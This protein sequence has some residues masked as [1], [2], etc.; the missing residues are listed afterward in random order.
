MDLDPEMR[1]RLYAHN[2]DP[3]YGPY[4][5]RPEVWVLQKVRFDATCAPGR[6]ARWFLEDEDDEQAAFACSDEALAWIKAR[7]ETI[8]VSWSPRHY[9]YTVRARNGEEPG[10]DFRITRLPWFGEKPMETPDERANGSLRALASQMAKAHAV[11]S[12][13]APLPERAERRGLLGRLGD[14]FFGRMD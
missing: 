7:Y 13:V 8:S 6:E 5:D 12:L 9:E 4:R 11:R 14:A 10:W 2:R 1:A 3:Q